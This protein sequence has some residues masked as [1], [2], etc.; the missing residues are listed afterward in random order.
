[1][2]VLKGADIDQDNEINYQEFM[3]SL[4]NANFFLNKKNMRN[5]FNDFDKN[6]DG[7]IGLDEFKELVFVGK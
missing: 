6:K 4:T 3:I 1:M 7:A 5:A 2:E